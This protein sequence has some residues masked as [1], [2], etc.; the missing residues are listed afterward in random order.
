MSG[1]QTKQASYHARDDLPQAVAEHE[2]GWPG[3][4]I[5]EAA[6]RGSAEPSSA[7]GARNAP[8]VAGYQIL[9]KTDRSVDA[10]NTPM[11]FP[12][13]SR[14]A[15]TISLVLSVAACAILIIASNFYFPPKKL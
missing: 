10:R 13:W 9:E 7:R 1:L 15:L 12:G 2:P 5:H 14:F 3:A 4:M 11:C 6:M 8:R